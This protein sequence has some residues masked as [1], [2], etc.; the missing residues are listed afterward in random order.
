MDRSAEGDGFGELGERC[1]SVESGISD[2]D[3]IGGDGVEECEH[4]ARARRQDVA[5]LREAGGAVGV[6]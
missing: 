4:P 1:E 5:E 3:D 6:L 2:D